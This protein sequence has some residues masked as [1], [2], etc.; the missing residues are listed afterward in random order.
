MLSGM[1][2]PLN[3]GGVG[4]IDCRFVKCFRWRL[5][6]RKGMDLIVLGPWLAGGSLRHG[7]CCL[8]PT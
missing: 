2:A 1:P 7:E 5:A 3:L 4:E 6:A 8:T